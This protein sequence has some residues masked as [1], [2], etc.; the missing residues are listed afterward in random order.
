MEPAGSHG[1]YSL[2]DFQF[3]PFVF[4]SS[5]LIGKPPNRQDFCFFRNFLLFLRNFFFHIE[6]HP[7]IEPK[8]FVQESNV[9][10]YANEFLF[11]SSVQFINSVIFSDD[12]FGLDLKYHST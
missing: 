11:F 4:G 5:Q 3:L 10:L 7:S 1:V 6:D 9:D 8:H 2:D 12:F